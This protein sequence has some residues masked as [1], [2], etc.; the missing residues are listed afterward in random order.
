MLNVFKE[1]R[2]TG[3]VGARLHFEDNT[4]QHDGMLS[5]IDKKNNFI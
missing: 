2:L 5:Y 4:I 3:T 1:N